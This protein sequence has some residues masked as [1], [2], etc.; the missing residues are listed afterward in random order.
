MCNHY[1][2]NHSMCNH[3][4]LHMHCNSKSP[5]KNCICLYSNF[6]PRAKFK[7]RLKY[8]KWYYPQLQLHLQQ[9]HLHVQKHLFFNNAVAKKF[10]AYQLLFLPNL[11]FTSEAY[12]SNPPFKFTNGAASLN[13]FRVVNYSV[14]YSVVSKPTPPSLLCG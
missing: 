9:L 12:H 5:S 6:Y 13:F 14:L 3:C 11:T 4:M 10:L 1:I 2:C 7:N 8:L